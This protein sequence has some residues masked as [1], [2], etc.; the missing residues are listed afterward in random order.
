MSGLQVTIWPARLACGF[1]GGYLIVWYLSYLVFLA[2]IEYCCRNTAVRLAAHDRY[3]NRV[4]R[5]MGTFF[6]RQQSW[7]CAVLCRV[8]SCRVLSCRVGVNVNVNVV[9]VNVN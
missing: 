3:A 1:F 9:N 6:S 4:L 7:C 8:V 2:N 5:L